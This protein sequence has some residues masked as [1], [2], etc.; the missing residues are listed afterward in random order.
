MRKFH[1]LGYCCSHNLCFRQNNSA[2]L[3]GYSSHC[4]YC[5]K[6]YHWVVRVKNKKLQLMVITLL[7]VE[8]GQDHII[9]NSDVAEGKKQF[10]AKQ[11]AGNSKT[12]VKP[13]YSSRLYLKSSYQ[14][15]FFLLIRYSMAAN[16]V[17]N[18]TI[19]IS[20]CLKLLYMA[21]TA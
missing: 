13:K 19:I 21:A 4:G 15:I 2:D 9:L 16:F 12:Q 17:N 7:N 5:L 18:A 10:D 11:K 8:L 20:L 3:T 6:W 1:S 14:A